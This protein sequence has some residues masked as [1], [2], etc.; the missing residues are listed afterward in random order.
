[1]EGKRITQQDIARALGLNRSSISLAFSNHPSIPEKTRERI[2]AKAEAMG[3]RPD[4]M[5]S[6]LAAYSK[7]N[8]STNFQG[9]LI[10]LHSSLT[11]NYKNSI[12]Y[13][14]HHLGA[15]SRALKH[16]YLLKALDINVKGMS[17]Q[18]ISSILMARNVQGI[19]VCPQ[20]LHIHEV[21]LQWKNFSALTFGYSLKS[22]NLN[23]ACATHYHS[24]MTLTTRLRELGY[25]R[26]GFYLDDLTDRRTDHTYLSGFVTNCHTNPTEIF[27]PPLVYPRKK[28]HSQSL[29]EW[30]KQHQIDVVMTDNT[31]TVTFL[32]QNGIRVPEDIGVAC[33]A[34]R[35]RQTDIS[36]W[37]EN[38]I[39]VG[40]S[41]VDF[42]IEMIHRGERGI[43][44]SPS[45]VLVEG[46][47]IS[48][49]TLKN[50]RSSNRTKQTR[51][52]KSVA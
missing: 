37:Y 38:S 2:L 47:W 20:P 29:L 7:H 23:K 32:R 45:Y 5:L 13:S 41:A 42:L 44:Q 16:G 18:R 27:I 3:Y 14:Q 9:T 1:M 35:T 34:L 50:K 21:S 48:G 12:T 28:L 36:G 33:Y 22:P 40:E 43:P 39:G 10:W 17:P 46:T 31:N 51:L 26:I 4:P 8:R 30:I 25:R 6:A 52:G 24:T 11:F 15:K 49:A 19:L